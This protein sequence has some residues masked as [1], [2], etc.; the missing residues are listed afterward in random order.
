ML[1]W[2]GL[3]V[4]GV[5]VEADEVCTVRESVCKDWRWDA[6]G[7]PPRPNGA[8]NVTRSPRH[9]SSWSSSSP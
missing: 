3:E 9:A 5:E 1:D 6:D 8:T 7:T 2:M 4:G